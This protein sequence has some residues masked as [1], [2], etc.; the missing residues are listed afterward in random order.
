MKS[1]L[2]KSFVY[3]PSYETDLSKRVQA[4]LKEVRRLQK[5]N[6]KE[7]AEKVKP[8]NATTAGNDRTTAVS[9]DA[10]VVGG[11]FKRKTA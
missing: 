1:I 3:T 9:G 6:A 2:D 7:A 4:H 11:T 8:I 10:P 5:A